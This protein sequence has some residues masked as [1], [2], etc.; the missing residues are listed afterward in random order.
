MSRLAS[1]VER[2]GSRTI[3][4]LGDLIA[5]E[6]IYG[7]PAR[8]SR[9]APVV[10]LRYEAREVML[11]GAANAS[12][13][14]H[15]IGARVIPIGIVGPDQAGREI[16]NLLK[17]IGIPDDGLVETDEQLTPVKT[18]IMAGGYQSTRHQMVR[19]DREPNSPISPSVEA[20]LIEKLRFFAPQT[21]AIVL[22]DY[23]Y[24]TAT[25]RVVEEALLLCRRN[26]HV[27]AADSRYD[28]IRFRGVT[29]ATP[30]EPEVEQLTGASLDDDRAV[31]KAG[32]QL[33]DRLD[34][35]YLLITRGSL[36]MALL[37]REGPATFFPIYGSDQIADVTGAGDIVITTFTAA[38]ASGAEA[39]EAAWLANL[40]GGMKVM[41]RGTAPVTRE[42]LLQAI[43][44]GDPHQHS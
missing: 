20:Q 14:V 3:L 19:V 29:A 15:T 42:E 40:A 5:D 9:E 34:A 27:V 44:H 6:Y 26:G 41:K 11:G 10:I 43:A 35:R 23:G 7:K 16:R 39:A 17:T 2:F 31:E 1:F 12:H 30:N 36:G 38:L 13:N 28:L 18:R 22:S 21:D 32:R 8:I 33:L 24:G 25:Q 4:V 37:E